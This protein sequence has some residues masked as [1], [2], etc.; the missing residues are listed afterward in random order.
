MA[1]PRDQAV[2]AATDATQ[3]V[4]GTAVATSQAFQF[5]PRDAGLAATI[6]LGRSVAQYR[7]SLSQASGQIL[8][9]GLIGNSLTVQCGATPPVLTPDQ[10]PKAIAAESNAGEVDT[11]ES[12]GGADNQYATAALGKTHVRSS[13]PPNEDATSEFNGTRFEVPGIVTVRGLA[14]TAHAHLYPGKARV[15]D[16]TADLATMQLGPV[17]LGG[18]HWETSVR[19]GMNPT[20][21]ST[22]TVSTV[23]IGGTKLPT[24]S[25]AALL[26]TFKAVN[27]ALE[28]TGLL[29]QL[30]EVSHDDAQLAMTPLSIGIKHS[31][32]GK[33][34]LVP[35]LNLVH[36]VFDPAADAINKAFCTFGSAYGAVNL[37]IAALDGV[38][39]FSLNFGGTTAQTDDATYANPFGNGDS[40][41]G[42][43]G[44]TLPPGG[45]TSTPAIGGDTGTGGPLP[46]VSDLPAPV[47]TPQVAG[48]T[49]DVASSCSTTSPAGRPSCGRGAGLAVGLIA[50]AALGGIAGAD[51]FVVRRRSRLARMA[52]ET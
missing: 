18:L 19:T 50:L 13:P 8:D 24:A 23:S 4:P 15:A 44:T 45:D 16:S 1:N 26:S 32:L 52:I 28:P 43:S 17:R 27:K 41:T 35:I 51:Y 46:A 3:F 20:S 10:L 12:L 29:V 49:R 42:T 36:T 34:L 40:D 22:F 37:M 11:K 33:M 48:G 31:A 38:G 21:S 2:V 25:T 6:T 14:S 39:Q 7:N 9:L 47:P 30:P 5:D